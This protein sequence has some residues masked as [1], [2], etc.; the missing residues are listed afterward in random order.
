MSFAEAVSLPGSH[1][2]VLDHE[3]ESTLNYSFSLSYSAPL[4]ASGEECS[5]NIDT[6][7]LRDR[8]VSKTKDREK[9]KF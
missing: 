3:G 9:N 4:P 1:T 2:V 8:E 5:V 6:L 7:H